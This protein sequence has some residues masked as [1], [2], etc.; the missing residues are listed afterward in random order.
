MIDDPSCFQIH[1]S[2][3]FLIRRQYFELFWKMQMSIYMLQAVIPCHIPIV[4]VA[5]IITVFT[6]DNGKCL[7]TDVINVSRSA[8][9]SPNGSVSSVRFKLKSFPENWACYLYLGHAI[10]QLELFNQ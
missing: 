3:L 2:F 6:S 9:T 5:V 4:S 8:R 10:E 1:F 7:I